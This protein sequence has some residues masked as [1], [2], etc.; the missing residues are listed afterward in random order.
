MSLE[1]VTRAIIVMSLSGSVIA[2]VLFLL[3]PLLR[4]RLPKLSQYYLWFIVLAAL[5]LP[6][7]G[8]IRFAPDV[9]TISGAV[10]ERLISGGE[11]QTRLVMAETGY[12]PPKTLDEAR[13]IDIA[14]LE[15]IA[16]VNVRTQWKAQILNNI[17]IL[18]LIGFECVILNL[19]FRYFRF[20]GKLKRRNSPAKDA[21]LAALSELCGG[22]GKTPRLYRNALVSTPM[23]IGFFK[24]MIL[25]PDKEYTDAQLHCV[26]LHELTHLRR[27]D[28]LVKWLTM[29]ACALHWFNPIVWLV[30]REIDRAA[31]ISCDEAVIR[32]LDENGIQ[33]YGETLIYVAADG[34]TIPRAVFSTTMCEEKRQLKERLGSIMKN[35]QPTRFAV[36]A[37]VVLISALTLAACALG[38]GSAETPPPASAT[39]IL[40]SSQT[41][42]EKVSSDILNQGGEVVYLEQVKGFS[43][44]EKAGITLPTGDGIIYI[45]AGYT[46]N[47][48]TAA[49]DYVLELDGETWEIAHRYP[50]EY[51]VTYIPTPPLPAPA[52]FLSDYKDYRVE[53][54]DRDPLAL[55]AKGELARFQYGPPE[56]TE[57]FYGHGLVNADGNIIVNPTYLWISELIGDAYLL[58]DHY[59][60]AEQGSSYTLYGLM[61]KNGKVITEPVWANLYDW[62]LIDGTAK[63]RRFL[64]DGSGGQILGILNLNTG[65]VDEFPLDKVAKELNIPIEELS[66]CPQSLGFDPKPIIF[67]THYDPN[68]DDYDILATYYYDWDGTRVS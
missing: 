62:N 41:A 36:V 38:A 4:E 14:G 16:E 22:S 68:S 18:P 53:Y 17:F 40:E 5:L 39:A 25:L 19:V 54:I 34:S 67:V 63:V 13:Q 48:K 3:K 59:E 52:L 9:P 27:H 21:E 24:P 1:S 44:A 31:E 61:D 47:G 66:P 60:N 58:N 64:E 55:F 65:E 33:C 50:A 11:Y 35:K 56:T 32:R 30:R 10:R 51:P 49:Y 28:V 6:A 42:K 37:S 20:K 57:T 26:L 45:F 7:S 8:V 29:L 43:E 46:Q 23:L 2:L 12:A 15:K